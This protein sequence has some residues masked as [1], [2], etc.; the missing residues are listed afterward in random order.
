MTKSS[1]SPPQER[2]ITLLENHLCKN[3]GDHENGGRISEFILE[4]LLSL[5]ASLPTS[6]F[7]LISVLLKNMFFFLYKWDMTFYILC[8]QKVFNRF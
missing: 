6:I 4:I 2:E 7:L 3:K 8:R 1:Q 5:S